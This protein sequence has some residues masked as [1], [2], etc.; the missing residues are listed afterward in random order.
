MASLRKCKWAGQVMSLDHFI[1]NTTIALE[2]VI[3]LDTDISNE[4]MSESI[5]SFGKKVIAFL[6]RF[7]E[8]IKQTIKAL[9]AKLGVG[10]TIKDIQDLNSDI[11]KARMI[12]FTFNELKKLTKLGWNVNV[13]TSDGRTADYTA[14]DMRNGY[15][16]Y[17][18]A[19]VRLI[20][21]LR[22]RG[23][24]FLLN[25]DVISRLM[26]P[27]MDDTYML[28]GSKPTKFVY[29]TFED[30]IRIIQSEIIESK[31]L[32]PFDYPAH[33]AEDDI[34]YL[35]EIMKRYEIT[36]PSSKF[37]ERHLDLSLKYLSDLEGWIDEGGTSRSRINYVKRMLTEIIKVTINDTSISLVRGIHGVYRVYA[38]AV[39][40][41][42][43]S[44]KTE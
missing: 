16:A 20:E 28:F 31:T 35:L 7:I 41:L 19:I 29:D 11:R 39:R 9:F 34:N 10:I 15:D 27:A 21:H 32:L 5:K 24:F 14:K 30:E 40:R 43:Y 38:G 36:G 18:N 33:Y 2:S 37:I 26:S 12:K 17:A 4:G 3:E 6:I 1:N 8:N 23:S 13:K 44:N 42:K 22:R 25:G